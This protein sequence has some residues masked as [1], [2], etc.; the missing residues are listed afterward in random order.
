MKIRNGFVSNSSSSS[1]VIP[2]NNGTF[3]C[4]ADIALHM[5]PKRAVEDDDDVM[6]N[7]H[8]RLELGMESNHPISFNSYNFNTFIVKTDGG[9]F[10]STCNNHDWEF[11]VGGMSYDDDQEHYILCEMPYCHKYYNATYDITGHP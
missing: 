10:V 2:L 7:I 8:R 5:I 4:V 11:E 3:D 1:F 6:Y 9:F